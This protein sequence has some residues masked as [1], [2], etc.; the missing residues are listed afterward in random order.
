MNYG[1]IFILIVMI[2]IKMMLKVVF[3]SVGIFGVMGNSRFKSFN[4]S[5]LTGVR[6]PG[7]SYDPSKVDWA[8]VI[9]GCKASCRFEKRLCNFYIRA[10]AHDALSVRDRNGGADG[11]LLLTDDELRRV[12]NRHDL[13]AYTVSKNIRM[14]A[15]KYK[16]SV[17]DTLAICGAV[18]VEFL[19]GPNI[20][21]FNRT[22]LPFNVGRVDGSSPN[23]ANSLAKADINLDEFVSFGSV[24]GLSMEEMTALM[25]THSLIDSKGCLKVDGKS[26]CDPFKENCDGI[27]MF[28][29]S[30]SYYKDVCDM[31]TNINI[32]AKEILINVDN[33]F[34]LKTAVCK[35]TSKKFKDDATLDFVEAPETTDILRVVVEV[36]ENSIMKLWNY[37]VND[38]WLG[39]ACKGQHD[40]SVKQREIGVSMNKFKNSYAEWSTTYIRAYKRMMSI[41][42]SWSHFGG[43][44]ITGNE[45][46]SGYRSNIRGV[47]CSDCGLTYKQMMSNA[48][49][50][51]CHESCV[52]TTA[53]KDT[54][55]FSEWVDKE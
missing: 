5:K 48:V 50:K 45:C 35:Y 17:A 22:L 18:A 51:N 16:S 10:A 26:Y 7:V 30:N 31:Q 28:K 29:W 55:V 41:G 38:A 9:S 6:M 37:T 25:G 36:I 27:S 32:P 1:L 20:L 24:R 40:N 15:D 49:S 34:E 33:D 11:S 43:Y 42:V 19:G 46:W 52:C 47:R 3:V 54:D 8:S 2:M 44:P 4:L 39:R 13:F 12:E 21:A 53:F 23:P 14:L